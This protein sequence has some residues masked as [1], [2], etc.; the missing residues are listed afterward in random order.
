MK[1]CAIKPSSDGTTLKKDEWRLINGDHKSKVVPKARM[2]P[3][4]TP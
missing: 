1:I 4:L 2:S 3:Q